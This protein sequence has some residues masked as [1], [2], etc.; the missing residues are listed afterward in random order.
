M[1]TL[2][3]DWIHETSAD[4]R[5][6]YVLGR[7]GHRPVIV[8]GLNPSTAEPTIPDP[9]I[10]AV[11]RHSIRLGYHGWMMLN[12]FPMRETNPSALPEVA[13]QGLMEAALPVIGNL[14]EQYP[15]APVWAAWGAHLALR[16]YLI[17]GLKLLMTMPGMANRAWFHVGPLTKEGHPRHPLYL[18]GTQ[19]ASE[20]DA[21]SYYVKQSLR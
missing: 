19:E 18:S 11:E 3:P 17:E 5:L 20:F 15:E 7:V 1:L 2:F 4:N 9:T 14:L 21:F 12:L 6:R 16:P 10:K 8:I 13:H